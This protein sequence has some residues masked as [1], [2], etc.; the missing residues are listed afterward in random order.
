[1]NDLH[2]RHI[3]SFIFL[4]FLFLH[5]H[6]NAEWSNMSSLRALRQSSQLHRV[7]S[8]QHHPPSTHSCPLCS[9]H[10]T[11]RV[12]FVPSGCSAEAKGINA[13]LLTNTYTQTHSLAPRD[14]SDAEER[15]KRGKIT[16]FLVPPQTFYFSSLFLSL[17]H[18][19]TIASFIFLLICFLLK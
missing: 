3:V 2:S 10:L 15:E 16:A 18:I 9:R 17:C 1:M 7:L 14:I 5:L 11:L 19:S 4:F 12:T 8:F 13:A 6:M